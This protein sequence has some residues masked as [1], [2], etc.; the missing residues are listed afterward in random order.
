[1]APGGKR[2]ENMPCRWLSGRTPYTTGTP[3]KNV[4]K[5]Y[6][7]G[8]WVSGRT[9]YTTGP[10]LKNALKIYRAGRWN[11]ELV[12]LKQPD[13]GRS[14]HGYFLRTFSKCVPAVYG[15]RPKVQAARTT[16]SASSRNFMLYIIMLILA[17]FTNNTELTVGFLVAGT[18]FFWGPMVISASPSSGCVIDRIQHYNGYL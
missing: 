13:S 8:R 11:R 7:A 15:V 2:A 12:S 3:L 18:V 4:L 5:I 10:P 17:R 9:P 14:R 1:M 6:R 16:F